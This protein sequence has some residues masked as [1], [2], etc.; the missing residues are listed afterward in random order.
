MSQPIEFWFDFASTYSYVAAMRIE[1]EAA[2]R[3]V[4]VQWRPFLLGPIFAQRLG[5]KDSPFNV[6]PERGR[7]MQR[8]LERLCAQYRLDWKWPSV[9]PRHSVL[10]AKI[11]A[12]SCHEQWAGDLVRAIFRA[13]FAE[14][15]DISSREVLGAVLAELGQDADAVL[16]RAESRTHASAV[17][18]N[19]GRAA[20]L[21]IFG[22]PNFLVGE[23]L[24][25]G[26]DRLLEGLAFASGD[27]GFAPFAGADAEA[28]RAFAAEWLP[29]W[30]GNDPERL[31]SFY[32]EEARYLDPAV[33]HGLEGREALLAYFR[34]LLA[35]YP[36]WRW[37]QTEAVP[38]DG[39]FVNKWRALVP[40]AAG[41]VELSGVCL[42]WLRAG[43]IV[44]NEVFFDRSEWLPRTG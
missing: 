36:A 35:R 4:A 22:A 33:P 7:Y 10:A 17:R 25:F 32:S 21:G 43:K 38:M 3:G 31:V 11:A 19:T 15:R 28:A 30:T 1:A 37:T 29:A 8:D 27:R 41:E 23:E 39:G 16:A 44:R 14:D 6:Q 20:A 2:R 42:V 18:E 40:E 12:V 26:Q 9:F 13:N 24:F 34:R 5:I